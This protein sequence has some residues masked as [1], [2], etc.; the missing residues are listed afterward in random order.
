MFVMTLL[1]IAEAASRL[2]VSTR[3]VQH[4][5]VQG[6]VRQLARGIVDE[7]SVER[8]VAVR[9]NAH[10]RAWSEETAWGAVSLL[11]GGDADWMGQSQRSRLQ[12]RLRDIEAGE[13]VER[14]RNR[15]HVTRYQSHPSVEAQLRSL[16]IDS[17]HAAEE[18][19]LVASTKIDGYLATN[20]VDSAL[21]TYGLINDDDGN[22]TLRATTIDLTVV[23]GLA[24]GGV[25]LAALDYAES[26]DVREYRAGTEALNRILETFRE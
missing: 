4:L 12:A 11:S 25:V 15:A 24:Q 14:A 9:G 26:L 13:L 2:G 21:R 10:G 5:I 8:L 19:G 18:L 16:L 7:T 1:S 6:A 20:D 3:Q 23:S 22:V 17:A